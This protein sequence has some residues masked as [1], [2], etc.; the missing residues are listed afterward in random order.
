MKIQHKVI[1]LIVVSFTIVLLF[2][3]FYGYL[4]SNQRKIHYNSIVESKKLIIH[5]VVENQQNRA[6]QFVNDYS[7]WDDMVNY[8]KKPTKKWEEDNL[9]TVLDIYQTDYLWVYSPKLKCIFSQRSVKSMFVDTVPVP[10]NIIPELFKT[11]KNISFYTIFN[12]QIIQIFGGKVVGSKEYYQEN[13]SQNRGYFFVGKV[14][15]KDFLEKLSIYS[16]SEVDLDL[17]SKAKSK[18]LYSSTNLDYSVTI[19]VPLINWKYEVVALLNFKNQLSTVAE[20]HKIDQLTIITSFIVL[21]LTIIVAIIF[22]NNWISYPMKR[23]ANSL[24]LGDL[25][26]IENLQK[27]KDEFGKISKLIN[28]HFIIQKQLLFEIDE[29]KATQLE[30]LQKE[31]NLS[32]LLNNIN[33][34]VW[35]M[36]LDFNITYVTPSIELQTQYNTEEFKLLKLNKMFATSSKESAIEFFEQLKNDILNGAVGFNQY[37]QTEQ[38]FVCKNGATIWVSITA[39]PLYTS[40]NNIIGIHG[41]IINI[42]NYKKAIF[43]ADAAHE[44]VLKA[45]QIKS[46]FMANMSH[47]I[48]T[49]LNGIIGMTD[50]VLQNNLEENQKVYFQNIKL[51][52]NVL[53]EIVNDILD[54]S[55]IEAGKLKIVN[56]QFNLSDV[57]LLSLN[58]FAAKCEINNIELNCYIDPNIPESLFGDPI[59]IKQVLMNLISNSVKFTEKG[60]IELTVTS[61]SLNKNTSSQMLVFSVRDTGIGIPRDQQS[62][63]FES[64]SQVDKSFSKKHEGTG[65]GLTIS[66][67]LVQLMNGAIWIES[68]IG[69]GSTF[70]FKIPLNLTD[71]NLPTINEDW[72]S[73][74]KKVL[75]YNLI[76]TNITSLQNY[77]KHL[78]IEMSFISQVSS[79]ID[80]GTLVVIF[81]LPTNFSEYSLTA[82]LICQFISENKKIIIVSS[83]NV[84][85]NLKKHINIPNESLHHLIKPYSFNN[86]KSL[87]MEISFNKVMLSETQ[88]TNQPSSKPFS[89]ST[90]LVAEDNRINMMIIREML[91]KLGINVISATNGIESVEK[92][93]QNKVDLIFM[94]IHMP[95]MDGI[96]ATIN[97][98]ALEDVAKRNIPIVALTADAMPGDKEKCLKI[99]MTDYITKPY[100]LNTIIECLNKFLVQ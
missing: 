27:R 99:G 65:L 94:D 96:Q 32:L 76:N 91:I 5:N 34:V 11:Y 15:N 41:T 84:F 58:T 37:V 50:L 1:T 60:E 3:F 52:A 49:P 9:N 26:P 78:D 83:T 100:T 69:Q 10:N 40:N 80:Y 57:V 74:I 59:R 25:A 95:E 62:E 63:I 12:K 17:M 92:L 16:D 88:K 82:K 36:D 13:N 24:R 45:S 14:I 56:T 87:L 21:I 38:V 55:K 18:T 53:S 29:H 30:L 47:E 90:I 68:T 39:K 28:S 51:S 43:N 70:S 89:N 22:I 44:E 93:T 31:T 42:D 98:R 7:S 86:L 72:K 35:S 46:D 77:L 64:F 79:D 61:D 75:V 97:I 8:I 54:F 81:N 71:V 48:R 73:S 23:I 67:R 85:S 20:W 2:L 4:N 33:D 6:V 66:K 19:T